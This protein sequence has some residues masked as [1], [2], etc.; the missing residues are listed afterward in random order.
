MK[1]TREEY[2]EFLKYLAWTRLQAPDYRLGQAFLNYFPQISKR[3]IK[4]EHWGTLYEYNLFNEINDLA[5]Q[6]IID[7]WVDR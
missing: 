3:L 6:T 1:I 2:Q 7:Q 5:A 4:D